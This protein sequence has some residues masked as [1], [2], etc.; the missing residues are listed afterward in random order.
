VTDQPAS[1]AEALAILQTRL[2]RIGKDSAAI[3]PGKAGGS[4]WGYKYA[5]L[6][7]VT[8]ALL[9]VMGE[10]G[11]SFMAKPTLVAGFEANSMVFVLDYRLSHRSGEAESG[12]YPLPT[13][14]SPQAIGSAITYARRYC[15][16]AVTGAAPAEDDDDAA[17][18]QD[19]YQPPQYRSAHADPEH[20]R[21]VHGSDDRIKDQ[22]RAVR[23]R[24]PDDEAAS[25]EGLP[26]E[27][28]APTAPEDSPG[29]AS[30]D[31]K[32]AIVR[33]FDRLKV[34][35]R[36]TRLL[37][38][39]KHTGRE[40]GSSRELSLIEASSALKTLKAEPTPEEV[41]ADAAP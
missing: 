31:Q 35:S 13:T 16:L 9:P 34:F 38:L 14:G 6:A 25:W 39:S 26:G 27:L 20:Q 11:L 29:T 17:Q 30:N 15:L 24:G 28:A 7:A 33:E 8:A 37:W 2:P 10:L 23:R 32:W 4:A 3:M 1:L 19:E 36:E 5:D 12:Q 18:A 21:L 22:G 41:P 40:I